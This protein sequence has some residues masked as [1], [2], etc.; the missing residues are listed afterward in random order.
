MYWKCTAKP[1]VYP[2]RRRSV[3]GQRIL[4]KHTQLLIAAVPQTA[5]ET[6]D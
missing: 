2:A 4:M 5:I 3:A 6:Y 1:S